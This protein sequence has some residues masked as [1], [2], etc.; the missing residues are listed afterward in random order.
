MRLCGGLSRSIVAAVTAAIFAAAAMLFPAPARSQSCNLG[1]LVNAFANI[2]DT[3]SGPACDQAYADTGTLTAAAGALGILLAADPSAGQ[4]LCDAAN[5]A[6]SNGQSAANIN[7]M[8]SAYFGGTGLDLAVNDLVSALSSVAGPLATLSCACSIDQGVGQI[9]TDIGSCFEAALCDAVKALGGECNTCKPELPTPNGN[10]TPPLDCAK[11]AHAQDADCY[12]DIV[13]D[14]GVS[15]PSY[16]VSGNYILDYGN[17]CGSPR[18]CSCPSPM[19]LV[20]VPVEWNQPWDVMFTCQCPSNPNNKNDP[21]NTHPPPAPPG[22][23][24]ALECICDNTGKV[25]LPAG[26][27]GGICP[28]LIGKQCPPGQQNVD[29]ECVT[30]CADPTKVQMADGSCCDP[31]QVSQCGLCCR[32]GQAPN[33][34]TGNCSPI[35]LKPIRQ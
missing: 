8:V 32:S 14:T 31:K 4:S 33:P 5:T 2:G 23:A 3:L 21:N 30:P 9:A 28:N 22:V 6:F 29:N 7:N 18:F 26:G 27:A 13:E 25:A 20:Q 17:G 10:C 35:V 24:P 11:F 15:P 16:K 19:T 12:G 34:T 1:D